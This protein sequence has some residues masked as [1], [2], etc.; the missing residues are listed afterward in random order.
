MGTESEVKFEISPRDLQKLAATRILRRTGGQL[1]KHK[2]F[3]STYFDT[4]KLL[5]RRKGVSLR[6]RRAGKK[7]LQTIK[8]VNDGVAL[9]RGEWEHKL[10]SDEP[11][12]RAARGTALEPLL[13]RKLKRDLKP[14]FATHIQRTFFPLRPGNSRI[15]LALDEGHVRAGQKS[16]PVAKV[17]LELKRGRASDLFKAARQVVQLVPAKLA[18]KSKSQQGY[19]LIADQPPRAILA[20]KITLAHDASV[21]TAFQV[22]GRS[23]LRHIAANEPA[24]MIGDPEGVHQ[25]RIGVRRLR[26]AIAVFSDLVHCEQTEQIKRDLKWLAGKLGPVRDLDVFLKDKIAPFGR[27]DFPIAGLPELESELVYR[28]DIAAESAKAAVATARYRLLIFN[29]LEWIEDG[30]WLKQSHSH[31]GPKIGPFAADLFR[32]KIKGT[33]KKAR[34]VVDVDAHRRHKL[35]IAIKKLRYALYF[36][37]SLFSHDN[38]RLLSRYKKH[39]RSLQDNLGALNDIAVRQKLSVK[40][41]TDSGGPRPQLVAFAAGSIA[42]GERNEVKSILRRVETA[43]Q[44]LRRAKRFWN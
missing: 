10:R 44:K 29:I 14:I 17:E 42:G 19:D 31:R 20:S 27:A 35:R 3:V 43:A 22:I 4:G 11:D 37:E 2:Y 25:M 13:S 28:R 7:R 30:K 40:L 9:R 6:V 8:T 41:A 16:S 36:F 33:R 15:E 18:F 34:R 32:R 1:A 38:S 39:L 5:L 24:V 12:L 26:A 21:A 23:V